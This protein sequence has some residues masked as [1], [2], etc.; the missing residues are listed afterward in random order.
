M[1]KS[2]KQDEYI[3]SVKQHNSLCSD[4]G[5]LRDAKENEFS[6]K[7]ISIPGTSI[8]EESLNILES[9]NENITV[10]QDF[11]LVKVHKS[12]KKTL[13]ESDT[14]LF[15]FKEPSIK[16]QEEKKPLLTQ[17]PTTFENKNDKKREVIKE[18]IFLNQSK[19]EGCNT[20]PCKTITAK[21][22]RQTSTAS[23][24]KIYKKQQ[25]SQKSGSF[26]IAALFLLI[27]VSTVFILQEA[28][29]L[30]LSY[31]ASL[32]DKKNY[33]AEVTN[34]TTTISDFM[35]S[36]FASILNKSNTLY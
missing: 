32:L 22:A 29:I 16:K 2:S 20:A 14:D 28:N 10:K 8:I 13:L 4:K 23:A 17:I 3:P 7:G 34:E 24:K 36:N 30:D 26:I 11:G 6:Y 18:N 1:N 21:K 33:S 25:P 12:D 35:K 31:I 9:Q 19:A 27:L 15:I 5:G